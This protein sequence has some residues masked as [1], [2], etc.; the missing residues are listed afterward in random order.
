M[1]DP[2]VIEN[3][4]LTGYT[5]R[6]EYI[7]VPAGV[8]EIGYRAFRNNTFVQ[9][10][11]IP[12]GVKR[13]GDEAF[14]G[15]RNLRRIKLPESLE[16]IG[17]YAFA[18]CVCLR[19]IC[20]PA[21]L[22]SIEEH[23]F[24]NCR[25]LSVIN[26][27]EGTAVK[28]GAFR[29]CTL[30]EV[31]W[32]MREDFRSITD[33]TLLAAA[34]RCILC[35]GRMERA[36][37]GKGMTCTACNHTFTWRSIEEWENFVIRDGVCIR[38]ICDGGA[39][40][41]GVTKIAMGAFDDAVVPGLTIPNSVT[42]IGTGAFLWCDFALN[43]SLPRDLRRLEADVFA[44][45]NICRLYLPDKLE[46]LAEGCLAGCDQL[47]ELEIPGSVQVIGQ[48]AVE[49]CKS[50]RRIQ[51]G[52]GIRHIGKAAFARCA[53]LKEVTC[54]NTLETVSDRAFHGCEELTAVTLNDGLVYIGA[55][56]FGS[57]GRLE[58]VRIPASVLTLGAGAFKKCASLKKAVLP[59]TL[60]Y[61]DL[62]GV[63]DLHTEIVFE[64]NDT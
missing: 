40:P 64:Q 55:H 43:P 27:P 16:Y 45:S 21:A 35:G 63:F 1:G 14:C 32:G 52:E 19:E 56:A 44:G 29:G 12:H 4:V 49:E 11:Q 41:Q 18:D 59:R 5:G 7:A 20:L 60:E 46:Y 25:R 8:D 30:I 13:V 6:E 36:G 3:G 39:I 62:R 24:Q 34:D 22:L 31:D 48:E 28:G 17:R 37:D 38:H 51:L 58:T 50:L 61:M 26:I 33:S 9:Q 54:P 2:F 57:C 42:E 23:A 15:C 10:I 53:V 47:S